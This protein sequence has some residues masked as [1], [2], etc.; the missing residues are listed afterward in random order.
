MGVDPKECLMVGND[1]GDDMSAAL[2]GMNV[3]LLT[4]NIINSKNEDISVYPS[5]NFE[6]LFNYIKKTQEI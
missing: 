2:C 6:D 3:F 5:G 1:V 4:D